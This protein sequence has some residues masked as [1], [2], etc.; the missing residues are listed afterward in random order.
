MRT[1]EGEASVARLTDHAL[2]SAGGGVA[3]GGARAVTV[4]VTSATLG[5][6]RV[7]GEREAGV[8]GESWV[9]VRTLH[10]L[11]RVLCGFRRE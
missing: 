6:F 5:G 4:T 11:G 9:S 3:V 2:T 7:G 10:C 8:W 1:T